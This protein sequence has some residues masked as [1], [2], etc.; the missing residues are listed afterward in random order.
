MKKISLFFLTMLIGLMAQAQL[1]LNITGHVLNNGQGVSNHPVNLLVY[2]AFFSSFDST[3]TDT[4]GYFSFSITTP[5]GA[6]QGGFEVFTFDCNGNYL[7]DSAGFNPGNTT[8]NTTFNYCANGIICSNSF[9]YIPGGGTTID[10]YSSV[11][12]QAPYTFSWDFGDGS[13]ATTGTPSHTYN[14]PGTYNVCLITTDNTGCS[15]TTCQSVMVA[16]TPPCNAQFVTFPLGSSQFEFF[17][18]TIVNANADFFWDFGDGNTSN[19]MIPNHTYSSQGLYIVC[20]TVVDSNANCVDI[21]CDSVVVGQNPPP[22]V[23]QASFNPIYVQTNTY[24]FANNSSGG[25]ASSPLNYLWDFGDGSTSTATNPTHT[26]AANGTY[27]VCLTITNNQFNCFDTT[28]AVITVSGSGGGCAAFFNYTPNG[29]TSFSF[30]ADSTFNGPLAS[31]HWDFGDNN[32]GSGL[33]TAHTYN[34][35]GMYLVCLTVIDSNSNCIDTY[36][37][38]IIVGNSGG[39]CQAGFNAI[40][41]GGLSIFFQ[42]TSV[43]STPLF[44]LTSQW[45]FGDGTGSNQANPVHTYAS[46][47]TYT[48]CLIITDA[49]GCT[50]SICVPLT[51]TAT[52]GNCQASYNYFSSGSTVYFSADTSL[53]GP[54]AVYLWDFGDNTFGNGP[55]PSH[56][57]NSN[58]Y[59]LACLTVIDSLNGCTAVFCDSVLVGTAN[60]NISGNVF[61]DSNFVYNG[62]AY[63]IVH[64]SSAGTLTAIDTVPVTQSFYSFYN[65]TPGTYLI[66]AALTPASPVYANY[67]PTY[68]GD[69]LF[70][71]NATS[72]IVTNSNIFN[73]PIFLVMGN[74]PGGPGFIGGLISQGANKGPGDP[75]S[76]VEVMIMDMDGNPIAYTMTNANGEYEF[77]NLPY[78][79][80]KIVVEI[81]GKY[82][83]SW[84]ITISPDAPHHG[85]ADFEVGDFHITKVDVTGIDTFTFGEILGIYP[86]PA[87]NNIN[88]NLEF[89]QTTEVNIELVS[90]IGQSI[91]RLSAG[92]VLGNQTINMEL[93]DI[94]QG[95]YLIKVQADNQIITNRIVKQ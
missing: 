55:Y 71:N 31:Y 91:K 46:A 63:L 6:T 76:D 39:Q 8:Y 28:C 11:S 42:N 64:D 85:S 84:T 3:F 93:G 52:G 33:D 92:K 27:T 24:Y 62:L 32:F 12:G 73:P 83:E 78:G 35:P 72:T 59:Y 44:P 58:G 48:V 13:S 49:A 20:L 51:V 90:L 19:A 82:S 89:R 41:Q 7:V 15:D 67:M 47:G 4:A 86:N 88:I 75:L 61:A 45:S 18:D 37:D 53:N 38:S 54:F 10:F 60:Y 77:S 1:N 74:N 43:A 56:T 2:S 87:T 65:V 29:G 25:G 94:P 23:C 81:P 80:Y 34:S 57:Y 50:D 40:S 30:F 5:P 16:V 22:P 17:P 95:V 14:A 79:T 26:Y 9:Y 68:L 69:V 36:C 21:F 70:W 66:K